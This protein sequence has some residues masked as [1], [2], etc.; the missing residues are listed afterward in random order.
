MADNNSFDIVSKIEMPEVINAIQQALKEITTRFDLKDSKSD[1]EL[2]EK[3]SKII[4]TSVD[5]YKVKAVR[6][7]M[8]SKLV[9]RKV[10]LKGLTYGTVTPAA[11][12]T[13]R[14]EVTLQSG[15]T[16]EKAKELVKF[17]KDGKFKV[18]ASIMGDYVRVIGKD[19][20]TLQS[21]IAGLR[22]HDFNVDLQFTN[23]R[24]N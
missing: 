1:I 16:T 7:I 5:E 11:G 2:I 9:K 12:S 24:T 20:D 17:I 4:L 10:P 18:Q 15:L 6:D 14:Q 22:G 23:Y 13:V 8:D 3:D 19:R 21:V